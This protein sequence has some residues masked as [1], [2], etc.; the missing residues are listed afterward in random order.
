MSQIKQIL[1]FL[2]HGKSIK[3]IAR[4]LEVSRNTIRK[5]LALQK[6]SGYSIDQLLSFEDHQLHEALLP[7]DG[8]KRDE[9]YQ[10]LSANYDYYKAELR[11]VG[12]TRWLLWSEYR[13]SHPDGYSYSQFCWHLQRLA[14]PEKAAMANLPHQPADQLYVDFAGKKMEYIDPDTG[15]IHQVPVFVATLGMSQY[16]YAEA[17]AGQTT[18]AFLRALANALRFFCGVPLTIIPD[19][20]KAAVIKADRYEPGLNTLLADFAN[21]YGT[22]ILP[23]R[24]RKP[25]DKS[26]VETMV[27]DVYRN[28][29]APLR[30]RSFFSLDEIN[31]AILDRLDIWHDRPFQQREGSRRQCFV[32]AEH[33]ALQ[34]LPT[35]AFHIKKYRWLT[36]RKN[37][38]IQLA[39]DHHYYSIPYAYIGKK[40]H[41]IYTKHVV[42]VY[43]D[44]TLIASHQRNR[45][46]YKY[47]TVK[48]H[49][50]S[51]H[52][53][54]LDRSPGW[55]QS[56]A[57]GIGPEVVELI[58]AILAAR[59]HPEQAYRSCDGVLGLARKVGKPQ[60][61]K[62][63]EVA[64]SLGEPTYTFVKRLVQNGTLGLDHSEDTDA[65]P[66]PNHDNVRGKTY[67]QQSLNL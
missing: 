11:K 29:Y 67:Y 3:F 1:R 5:Y 38:H 23:A 46:R 9:R 52:Q 12:V 64:L 51:H 2:H 45:S 65:S 35:E 55:Y 59:P 7:G 15:Q 33:P 32:Q 53:Y 62:A 31:Q 37:S 36:V 56:R 6:A 42:Q 20:L 50:P 61:C 22:T 4:R 39:E 28:V 25:Q 24:P 16:S 18:E 40:V 8:Q 17:L 49:L 10:V 21:H 27:R 60:L 13:Q 57:E 48:D 41:L 30:N 44:Q 43:S 26:L 19:N 58:N 63:A 66:L 34:A 14:A 47:T 54:W